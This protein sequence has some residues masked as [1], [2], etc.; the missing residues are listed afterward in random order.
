MFSPSESIHKVA[1]CH[2]SFIVE[3]K[4]L[5]P[6]RELFYIVVRNY[7]FTVPLSIKIIS[8]IFLDD[9]KVWKFNVIEQLIIA[10]RLF[11]LNMILAWESV[12]GAVWFH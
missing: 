10:E 9:Q 5:N 2:F 4:N 1:V 6:I 7:H 3:P 11:M 8:R 12:K